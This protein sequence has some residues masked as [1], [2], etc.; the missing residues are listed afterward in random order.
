M[1]DVA[2]QATSVT[3]IFKNTHES[4]QGQCSQVPR[5]AAYLPASSR[6]GP[7]RNTIFS[8]PI[9]MKSHSQ[10]TLD[11][12]KVPITTSQSTGYLGGAAAPLLPR[13]GALL[14]RLSPGLQ[15]IYHLPIHLLDTPLQ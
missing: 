7:V 1:R 14:G 10:F 5:T 9:P 12:T 4:N 2:V 6:H 3:L 13:P 15:I 8:D 11:T